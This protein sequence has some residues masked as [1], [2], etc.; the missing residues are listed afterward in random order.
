MNITELKQGLAQ[1]IAE[2]NQMILDNKGLAYSFND[3][4]YIY[5][6]VVAIKPNNIIQFPIKPKS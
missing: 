3:G 2:N 6:V 5:D 1:V 4:E